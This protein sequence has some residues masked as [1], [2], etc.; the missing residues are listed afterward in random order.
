M[1]SLTKLYVVLVTIFFINQLT[2]S[3]NNLDQWRDINVCLHWLMRAL[4]LFA[5][6]SYCFSIDTFTYVRTQ[7]RWMVVLIL[8]LSFYSYQL[9]SLD[10]FSH[11]MSDARKETI[12]LTYLL[13][14]LPP[15]LCTTYLTFRRL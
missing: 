2:N 3:F 15:I 11:S 9:H 4:G 1:K 14:V 7:K 10:L 5:L 8:M 12:L 6:V 13:L